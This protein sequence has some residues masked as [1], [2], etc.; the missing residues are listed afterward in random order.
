M[1][2]K[3]GDFHGKKMLK[4]LINVDHTFSRIII[5]FQF[6]L[7]DVS[8]FQPPYTFLSMLTILEGKFSFMTYD[9]I[10]LVAH[11]IKFTSF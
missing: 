8:C 7:E 2:I 5:L 6:L 4:D 9:V 11:L 1:T 3:Y 10:S